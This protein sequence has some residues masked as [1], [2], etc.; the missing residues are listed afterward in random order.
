MYFF[1]LDLYLIVGIVNKF[2]SF[3]HH[4]SVA[5]SSSFSETR[6]Q[7][8]NLEGMLEL[9][10]HEIC[11]DHSELSN[12][13]QN[14]YAAVSNLLCIDAASC[15]CILYIALCRGVKLTKLSLL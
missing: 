10:F 13:D 7:L 9:K 1:Y 4:L 12:I 15:P 2:A 14:S 11:A 3:S 6:V 8:V 5:E